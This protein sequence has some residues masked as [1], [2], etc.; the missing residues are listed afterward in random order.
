MVRVNTVS[1]N[2]TTEERRRMLGEETREPPWPNILLPFTSVPSGLAHYVHS[3]L[4]TKRRGS[5]TSE[6]REQRP[7][8]SLR[9]TVSGLGSSCSPYHPRFGHS[10]RT[11]RRAKPGGEGMNGEKTRPEGE[12]RGRERHGNRGWARLHVGF[13]V[14]TGP[15]SVTVSLGLSRPALLSFAFR[16]IPS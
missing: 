1:P 2:Q 15:A 10:F 8:P 14:V 6:S 4:G 16:S 9:L 11:V 7:G 12:D 13:F 3:S 5:E